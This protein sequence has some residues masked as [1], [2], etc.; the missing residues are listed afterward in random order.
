MFDDCHTE[1]QLDFAFCDAVRGK[2]REE[3]LE[4]LKEK[5]K[6]FFRVMEE[7]KYAVAD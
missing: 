6:A 3:S 5:R 4:I 1:R 7:N 2:T